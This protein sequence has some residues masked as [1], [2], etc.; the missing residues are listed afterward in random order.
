[1]EDAPLTVNRIAQIFR[2]FLFDYRDQMM[3]S[4]IIGGYD[5]VEGPQV[6]STKS[7]I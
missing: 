5:E 1:M 6:G 4:I 7:N 3:A 2:S